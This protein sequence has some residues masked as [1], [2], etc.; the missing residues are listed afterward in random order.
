MNIIFIAPKFFPSAG[1]VEK[2]IL[3]LSKRLKSSYK[4]TIFVPS[5]SNENIVTYYQ[6]VKIIRYHHLKT[7]PKSILRNLAFFKEYYKD[8]YNADIVHCHDYEVFFNSYFLT[9]CCFFWKKCFITFHGWEG[10]YPPNL[11]SIVLRRL[12]NFMTNG[13]ICIGEYIPKIFG[14]TPSYISYGAVSTSLSPSGFDS[15]LYHDIDF[16]YVGRFE[17]DTGVLQ[18]MEFLEFFSKKNCGLRIVFCGDG[19]LKESLI[20]KSK[21]INA[22]ITFPGWVDDI[23]KYYRRS[24]FVLTSGYLAILEAWVNKKIV[25]AVYDNPIKESYLKTLPNYEEK[26]II[27]DQ[28]DYEKTEYLINNNSF[29]EKLKVKSHSWAINQTWEKMAEKYERLWFGKGR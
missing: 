19:S 4:T 22:N 5:D 23:D 13:N 20:A 3:E 17:N 10:V 24:K 28:E 1:G 2:H 16:L 11:R 27:L 29:T 8:F 26:I 21:G 6:G 7:H 12:A 9:R 15:S 14:V 25:I 18:Y